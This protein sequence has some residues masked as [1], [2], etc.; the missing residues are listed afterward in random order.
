MTFLDNVVDSESANWTSTPS[1]DVVH[2]SGKRKTKGSETEAEC[3]LRPMIIAFEFGEGSDEEGMAFRSKIG[4]VNAGKS[5]VSSDCA[6]RILTE[7]GLSELKMMASANAQELGP[8][9]YVVSSDGK[10]RVPTVGSSGGLHDANAV[11]TKYY[12][13]QSAKCLL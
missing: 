3:V 4:R 12:S 2:A 5:C 8:D 9:S 1:K 13:S 7:F 10:V 11:Q 6:D